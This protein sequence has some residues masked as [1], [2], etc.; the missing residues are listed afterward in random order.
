M[1]IGS[2]SPGVLVATV[3]LAL[4]L[5]SACLAAPPPSPAE[6]VDWLTWADDTRLLIKELIR[7]D[8]TNP[9]GGE[10][11][12][13]ERVKK[14]LDLEGIPSEL[15]LCAPGRANLV[16]RLS[17]G[18]PRPPVV[19]MAHVDVVETRDQR[20]TVPPLE[21]VERDG[22]LWGRGAIDSKA[23]AAL[24]VQLL[25][26]V[27]RSGRPLSRGLTLILTADAESDSRRGLAWL[28]ANRP[29]LLRADGVLMEGGNVVEHRGPVRLVEVETAQKT[30]FDLT[31]E[32]TGPATHGALPGSDSAIFRLARALTRL[33]QFEPPPSGP[34]PRRAPPPPGRSRPGRTTTPCS[35]PRSP[36]RASRRSPGPAWSPRPPRPG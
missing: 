11:Q 33:A 3:G 9:P 17:V 28:L 27:K 13:L 32:A 30:S 10:A 16:A 1:R 29:D 2:E 5:A 25:C 12:L 35:G 14:R 34:T 26:L 8:T 31:L 20:W 4:T 7:V 21:G 23:M 22:Y 19:W 15:L 18:D 6:P 36:P 24:G